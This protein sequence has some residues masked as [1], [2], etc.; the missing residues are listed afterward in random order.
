MERAQYEEKSLKRLR[1]VARKPVTQG[2]LVREGELTP[3]R[4]F[5]VLLEP[6][7]ADIDLAEWVRGNRELLRDLLARH[8]AVLLRGFGVRSE[9]EFEQVASGLCPELFGEYEDLPQAKS[10]AKVYGSTPYPADKTI[11]FHNESSHMHRWP[12]KQFFC[13]LTPALARGETPI[14][15]CR[16]IYRDLRPELLAPFAEQGLRYVR[17]FVDGLDV[18][19]QAFFHTDDRGA[20][21]EH[22]RRSGIRY[23]WTAEGLRT[24]QVGPAVAKHPLTGETVFFNQMQVHHPSCLDPDLRTP[25]TSLYGERGLPR[26]VLYGDGSPIPD[27]VVAEILELYWAHSVGFPWQAGDVLMLDNMLVA[28]ARNPYEG[29][30]K[31][32]VAM[33][34][35]FEKSSL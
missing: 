30:R 8:G 10:A 11:L 18:S 15:D 13:C 6:A 34:E 20:V 12:L 9:Q 31:I 35:M 17:T 19:W 33:G 4:S 28:H 7:A 21:E 26:N 14:V 29:P 5:P 16:E 2:A 3:G 22:C 32:A 1:A 24:E 23:E 27:E 25:L